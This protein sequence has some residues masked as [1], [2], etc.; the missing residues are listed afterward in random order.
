MCAGTVIK[1]TSVHRDSAVGNKSPF[2]QTYNT[3]RRDFFFHCFRYSVRTSHYVTLTPARTVP[4]QFV[5]VRE[6]TDGHCFAFHG[7][8]RPSF[9][10][11]FSRFNLDDFLTRSVRFDGRGFFHYEFGRRFIPDRTDEATTRSYPVA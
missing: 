5:G 7:A 9:C 2:N 1:I 11:G 6:N 3:V 4:S 10:L 8:R